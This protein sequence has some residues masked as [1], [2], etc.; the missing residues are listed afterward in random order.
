MRTIFSDLEDERTYHAARWAWKHRHI[1]VPT[2]K[3]TWEVWFERMFK[4]PLREYAKRQIKLAEQ[5]G[6]HA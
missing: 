1:K 5:E 2:G 4:E 6:D 3:Y